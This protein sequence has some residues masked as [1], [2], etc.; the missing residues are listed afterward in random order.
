MTNVYIQA[1]YRSLYDTTWTSSYV[2]FLLDNQKKFIH[3]IR[4]RLPWTS[5]ASISPLK[6]SLIGALSQLPLYCLEIPCGL[7]EEFE[8]GSLKPVWCT[9]ANLIQRLSSL[10]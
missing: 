7:M 6:E 5:E 2:A 4:D 1:L 9:R 3:F 10:I 8:A